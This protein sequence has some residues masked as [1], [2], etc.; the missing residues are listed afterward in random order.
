[1]VNGDDGNGS[2]K[3]FLEHSERDEMV[4][5]DGVGGNGSKIFLEHSGKDR[6]VNNDN[7]G[8]GGVRNVSSKSFKGTVEV[9]G[10][11]D[12]LL[13]LSEKDKTVKDDG[14]V[15]M[16]KMEWWYLVMKKRKE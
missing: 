10:K 14:G 3:I 9:S 2:N 7:G 4:Y 16:E 13:E 1:M 12:M 15:E 8:V 5:G 6:T 11:D